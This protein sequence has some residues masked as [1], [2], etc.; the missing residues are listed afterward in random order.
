MPNYDKHPSDYDPKYCAMLI[1]H[2]AEGLSY[3]TFAAKIGSCRSTLYNWEKQ[4]PEW[5][6]TKKK[7]LEISQ[8]WWEKA[9]INGLYTIVEHGDDGSYIIEKRI[10]SAMW[11]FQMKARF[12]WRDS[13]TKT[14][15][16]IPERQVLTL[17]DK[18]KLL[19]QA[20]QEI[21]KLEAEVKAE[22]PELAK[23]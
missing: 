14:Q 23:T 11:I 22:M 7:A 6:D 21:E 17:E 18:K 12:R 9:G 8:L 20:K 2:M 15:E 4:F 1:E 10:N 13:E 3:E 19:L 5:L 16:Q